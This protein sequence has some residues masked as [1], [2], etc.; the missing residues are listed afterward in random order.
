VALGR[1]NSQAK[2][3]AALQK[4]LEDSD[5]DV[6]HQAAVALKQISSEALAK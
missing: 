5:A 3:V 1:F 6:R 2:S 4:A